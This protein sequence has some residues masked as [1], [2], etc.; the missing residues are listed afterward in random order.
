MET[1]HP[2]LEKPDQI[3]WSLEEED[4]SI[5]SKSYT[6]SFCKKGF[7]NAQALGGHMN[8]HRKDRAKLR[9]SFEENVLISSDITLGL[10][11]V[12]DRYLISETILESSGEK[13]VPRDDDNGSG[14]SPKGKDGVGENSRSSHGSSSQVELDLE[15]RLGPDSRAS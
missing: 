12:Q 4:V 3:V 10:V 8:I 11:Q 1:K 6:C 5:H 7:S 15:L 14:A 9:E 13:K 2:K